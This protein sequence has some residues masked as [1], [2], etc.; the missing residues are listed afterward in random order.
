MIAEAE[1]RLKQGDDRQALEVTDDLLA[2]LRRYGV[3]SQLPY[4]F[5]LR[6]RASMGLGEPESARSWW[7][8]AVAEAKAMG[9]RRI[10]WRILYALSQIEP[11]PSQAE[12]LLNGARDVLKYIVD[13]I[14]QAELR[15]SFLNQPD[16]RAVLP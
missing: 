2:R 15:E 5:L 12:C 9:S 1:L 10:L 8:E 7:M 16:V 3:R 4:V 13:H 11:E 14:D 6:G